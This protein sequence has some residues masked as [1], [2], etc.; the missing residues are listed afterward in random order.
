MAKKKKQDRISEYKDEHGT[1]HITI[2]PPTRPR[3]EF[4]F[5][6]QLNTKPHIFVSKKY[7]KPKYPGKYDD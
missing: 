7:R 4:H 5:H 1:V 3:N 2:E 6:I